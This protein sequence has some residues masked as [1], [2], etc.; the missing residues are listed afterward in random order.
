MFTLLHAAQG[1]RGEAILRA[2]ADRGTGCSAARVDEWTWGRTPA[3]NMREDKL[4][5]GYGSTVHLSPTY[6]ANLDGSLA[7][8]GPSMA[9]R[10]RVER[11]G[12]GKQASRGLNTRTAL[13]S[14][15]ATT[16]AA[17]AQNCISLKGSSQCPAF[18]SSSISTDSTLVGLLYVACNLVP[19]SD[20]DGYNLVHFFNSFQ[21]PR[22]STSN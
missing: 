22:H 13:L 12:G 16:P 2:Q 1:E 9:S 11:S 17:M 6:N 10:R 3:R 8:R 15:L 14:I 20:T 5:A 21:I 19:G 18:S 4:K 7:E